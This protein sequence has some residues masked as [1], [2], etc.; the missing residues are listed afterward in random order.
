MSGMY[1]DN[2]TLNIFGESISWPGV[3]G[4]G[5]FTNGDFSDPAVRPSFI[6][7]E[8]I[9]LILDN[10]SALIVSL[11]KTPNNTD[12]SQLKK[13]LIDALGLKVD[14]ITPITPITGAAAKKVAY[15]AQGQITGSAD[16][17]K[18]DIGLGNVRNVDATDGYNVYVDI[19]EDMEYTSLFDPGH[20]CL[21][22]VIQSARNNLEYLFNNK[23]NKA[24]A[25]LTYSQLN[26]INTIGNSTFL[27]FL[28]AQVNMLNYTNV[29][30][31]GFWTK[32]QTNTKQTQELFI[33][34]H[35]NNYIM[36]KWL[37]TYN[38]QNNSW[39]PWV[40][41]ADMEDLRQISHYYSNAGNST[42]YVKYAN[43][44]IIQGITVSSQ[45]TT[46]TINFPHA[47]HNTNYTLLATIHSGGQVVSVTITQ[48]N[49][50]FA[51]II[52]SSTNLSVNILIMGLAAS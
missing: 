22:D 4:D 26:N 23:V 15:N 46:A 44:F 32:D 42:W 47:M 52:T 3:G 12:P 37:R 21:N 34:S 19:E 11:G 29:Y 20:L 39:L 49:T 9:N 8:T 30:A 2:Q 48:K 31:T 38:S 24:P 16:L 10:L 33:Y 5:K 40:K 50:S 6:P 18:S 25:S 51:T 35:D 17:T 36:E 45:T 27:P 1:P 43:N 28:L 7:A 13:A 14:K 41:L